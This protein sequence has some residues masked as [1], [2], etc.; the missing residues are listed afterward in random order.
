[1]AG[2]DSSI[3]K[4]ILDEDLTILVANASFYK[5]IG[6][7]KEDFLSNFMGLRQYLSQ[8]TKEFDKLR[9]ALT[10][11]AA[12]G[13]KHLVTAC[14]LPAKDG[15]LLWFRLNIMLTGATANSRPMFSASLSDITEHCT[16]DKGI[17]QCH[18]PCRIH[19]IVGWK[20]IHFDIHFKRFEQ[21]RIL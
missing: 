14:L 8:H 3:I 21:L 15:R 20:A 16:E 5:E 10:E 13:S 1:M 6:Y 2:T 4:C 11:A 19:L 17:G 7:T 18:K 12:N 9:L